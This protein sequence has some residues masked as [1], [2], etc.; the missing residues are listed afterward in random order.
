MECYLNAAFESFLDHERQMLQ[1]LD[2]DIAK[3]EAGHLAYLPA[4]SKCST[5]PQKRKHSGSQ[6]KYPTLRPEGY[7]ADILPHDRTVIHKRGVEVL[8]RDFLRFSVEYGQ[9]RL[10]VKEANIRRLELLAAAW[11]PKSSTIL[12]RLQDEL[13]DARLSA[14]TTMNALKRAG[15]DDL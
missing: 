10:L 11:D 7:R 5:I 8:L 4:R 1:T 9:V 3:I 15:V 13:S 14:E 2:D 12:K 6:K